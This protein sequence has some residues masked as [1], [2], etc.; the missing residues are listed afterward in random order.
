MVTFDPIQEFCKPI[1]SPSKKLHPQVDGRCQLQSRFW[2]QTAYRNQLFA[3]F[4]W[5]HVIFATMQDYRVRFQLLDRS[6]FLPSGAKK[7]QRCFF[8]FDVHRNG[9]ATGRSNDDIRLMQIVFCLSGSKSQIEVVIIEPG[10]DDRMTMIFQIGRLDATW[11][12]VPTVKEEDDH[13]G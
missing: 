11:D 1:A 8:G 7:N 2:S 3:I 12:R 10:I 6:P 4:E 9:T 13:G 5:D